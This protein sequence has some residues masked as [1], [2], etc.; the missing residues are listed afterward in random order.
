MRRTTQLQLER[1][2]SRETPS[3][4]IGTF[5]VFI[6]YVPRP[7]NTVS[8]PVVVAPTPPLSVPAPNPA[9]SSETTTN[10]TPTPAPSPSPSTS[11]PTP[12]PPS[13][14]PTTPPATNP[15]PTPAP[16]SMLTG[17]VQG[18][19]TSTL[20]I[21]DTPSGFHFSGT[22]RMGELGVV[23]VYAHVYSVGFK[24]KG[25]ARGE[26]TISNGQGSLR[27]EL[28][29]PEQARLAPLPDE[30]RYRVVSR[31]GT[32]KNIQESGVLRISR[33]LDKVPIR[34]GIQYVETGTFRLTI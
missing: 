26:M 20:R 19:Y 12:T 30:F 34:N 29:G 22:A 21:V 32:L 6:S 18:S 14:S 7:A 25:N 3:I 23:N 33:T 27:L 5:P 15:T 10:P 8:P 24:A 13:P 31:S 28:T 9:A 4:K 1:L 11:N 2:E 17:T 16:R